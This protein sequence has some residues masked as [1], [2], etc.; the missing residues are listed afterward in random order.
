M[1]CGF[2]MKVHSTALRMASRAGQDRRP[3]IPPVGVCPREGAR[4]G[5]VAV[6]APRDLHRMGSARLRR[7]GIGLW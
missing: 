5:L 4:P 6:A 7:R 3:S 1:D 2:R